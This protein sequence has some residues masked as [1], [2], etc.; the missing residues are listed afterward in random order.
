MRR[1][2]LDSDWTFLVAELLRSMQMDS[3]EE[4]KIRHE[5][6]MWDLELKHAREILQLLTQK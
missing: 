3:M 4:L 1:T 6:E 5:F 2:H